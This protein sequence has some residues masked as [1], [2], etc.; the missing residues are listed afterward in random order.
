M[1]VIV[2]SDILIEVF[3]ARNPELLAKWDNLRQSD[4]PILYS[5][6]SAAEVWAGAKP[7]E[8]DETAKLFESLQCIPI[9]KEIGTQAG[10]FIRQFSKSHKLGI[11]DALIAASAALSGADLWTRNRKH[12]PMKELSFF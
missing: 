12:F 4:T 11:A 8:F 10:H 7:N 1:A 5:P 2:D 6:V 3:N 9:E